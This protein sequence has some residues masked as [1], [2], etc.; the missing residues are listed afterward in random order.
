MSVRALH[1]VN[2][3]IAVGGEKLADVSRII[4]FV[5]INLLLVGQGITVGSHYIAI[6]IEKYVL[7][8]DVLFSLWVHFFSVI[9]FLTYSFL[10]T[11]EQDLSKRE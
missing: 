1:A 9:S 2:T 6:G 4:N 8:F 3:G 7:T 10:F 5:C 11:E